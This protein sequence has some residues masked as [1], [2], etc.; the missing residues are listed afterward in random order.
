MLESTRKIIA[1]IKAVPPGR[2]SS[3]RDIALAAGMP[4]GAR[5]VA[6]VLHSLSG[7]EGL[8]WH[9][10]IRA[11]GGIA[12][13]PG[14]GLELQAALLRSEGVEVSPSG[15]VDMSRFALGQAGK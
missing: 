6:R 2:V 10:I 3:Y 15:R 1:L 12:L 5:Q 7:K 11:G 8:P 14:G 13:P 4:G 9:R